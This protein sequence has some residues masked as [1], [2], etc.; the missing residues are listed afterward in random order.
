VNEAVEAGHRDGLLST[1]SLMVGEAAADD[2]VARARRLPDLRVGLHV[3]LAEGTPVSPPDSIPD[4][5][6]EAG[7]FPTDMVRAGFRFFF[8]PHVRRQL[9]GEIRAQF[10]AFA[11]T[12]LSL[13]H[14]NTHKHF[15]LHPTVAQLIMR[16]GREYGLR[17]VRLPS[18]PAG[19][20]AAAGTSSGFGAVALRLWTAQLRR[21]LRRAGLVTNDQIFGLA[22]S[23]AM[24]EERL[25]RLIPHL[26][27]GVSEIYFHPAR[28]LTP[29]LARTMPTYQ[30]AEELRALLSP[31]VRDALE[32][33]GIDRTSF[34]DLADRTT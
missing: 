8:L 33:A 6:D 31:K 32:R 23:G 24:T 21:Q 16:I 18:E 4:L 5:V 13:D 28:E 19:P 20:L 9:E 3:V 22:W 11:R 30:H 25:L 14:A 34:S 29:L 17:A 1:T 12:G 15:H 26:P 27:E 10:A 7:R 2:A